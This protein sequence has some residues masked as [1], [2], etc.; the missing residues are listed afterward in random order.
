M[1]RRN[2]QTS[3][4]FIVP[5]ARFKRRLTNSTSPTYAIRPRTPTNVLTFL[6]STIPVTLILKLRLI[7]RVV[8][9]NVAITIVVSIAEPA[10]SVG[11]LPQSGYK[12]R[13]LFLISKSFFYIFQVRAK[14][15]Y[16]LRFFDLRHFYGP[17]DNLYHT[18]RKAREIA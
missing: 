8:Y 18:E 15:S 3:L 4:S 12:V 11:L 5:N 9:F 13:H 10:A 1:P 16:F 6:P 2:L 7:S 17:D 14:I